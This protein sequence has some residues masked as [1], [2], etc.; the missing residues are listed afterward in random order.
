MAIKR[1][2]IGHDMEELAFAKSYDSA[3]IKNV[4]GQ[5]SRT[6]T[7]GEVTSGL[8][9]VKI[10]GGHKF[11]QRIAKI[12]MLGLELDD[13]RDWFT[14]IIDSVRYGDSFEEGDMFGWRQQADVAVE[15]FAPGNADLQA[16]ATLNWTGEIEFCTFERT[17][18]T[19][20]VVPIGRRADVDQTKLYFGEG[21]Q[22]RESLALYWEYEEA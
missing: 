9:P 15:N 5:T 16:E 22:K 20:T 11:S 21:N 8:S 3:A 18:N 4:L 12:A 10:N 6:T 13:I 14:V 17:G 1:E 2:V 19:I 7:L